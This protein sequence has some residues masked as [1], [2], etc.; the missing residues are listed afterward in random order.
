[1][2]DPVLSI[3]I[4]VWDEPD[5]TSRCLDSIRANTDVPYETIGIDNGSGDEAARLVAS[6]FDIAIRN[7]TNRGFAVAMNQGL[8]RARGRIAAFLNNDT[9]V[10]PGWAATLVSNF[11]GDAATALVVPAVTAAGN[12]YSVRAEPGTDIITIPPFSAI[13]SG[14]AYLMAVDLCRELGGWSEEY[15]IASSEDLDLLFTVWANGGAIVFDERVL[16]RHASAASARRLPDRERLWRSNRAR[17]VAKWSDPDA[18]EIPRRSDLPPSEFAANLASAALAATWMQR[19]FEAKDALA[20]ADRAT[21]NQETEATRPTTRPKPTRR[22][23]R[24]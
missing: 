19:W 11:A 17:F 3:I 22:L 14:V 8:K 6:E 7:D 18:A 24:R 20:D 10:P 23:R 13:P 16:I 4:P 5:L 2:A 21:P 9:E 1:M 15:E 12:Y